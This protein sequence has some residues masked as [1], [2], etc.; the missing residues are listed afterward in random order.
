MTFITV[1][2]GKRV[3]QKIE[4][5]TS[6]EH[7]VNREFSFH[8]ISVI[9]FVAITSAACAPMGSGY[10]SSVDGTNPMSL[11]SD[12]DQSVDQYGSD[13]AIEQTIRAVISNG[14]ED[15]LSS[16]A[17][18]LPERPLSEIA[19]FGYQFPSV[20]GGHEFRVYEAQGM[21]ILEYSYAGQDGDEHMIRDYVSGPSPFVQAGLWTAY[22][23]TAASISTMTTQF[24]KRGDGLFNGVYSQGLVTS[25]PAVEQRTLGNAYQQAI[26][27]VYDCR[28]TPTLAD[29][30]PQ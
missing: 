17:I 16:R 14:S 8:K 13:Y 12:T 5:R 18:R 28:D 24:E 9:L 29:S 4:H 19:V 26:S 25:L 21:Q 30:S 23:H 22:D 10:S 11:T 3:R 2:T 15:R 1:L 6:K 7:D 20:C 27:E